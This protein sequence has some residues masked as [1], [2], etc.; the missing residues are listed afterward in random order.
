LTLKY[1]LMKKLILS[2]LTLCM[3]AMPFDSDAW[4]RWSRK[5]KG[6]AVGAASG[7]V[8]G[9]VAKGKKGAVVGAA[10]GAGS[11]YLIG[12]HRDRKKGVKR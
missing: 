11:G 6:T 3:L 9:G 2:G 7:A 10:V 12:R 4:R 1:F 8:I 5:G